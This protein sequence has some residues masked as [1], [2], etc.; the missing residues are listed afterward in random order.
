CAA[1]V[2]A[3]PPRSPR[4]SS[5]VGGGARPRVLEYSCAG[6]SRHTMIGLSPNSGPP[7]RPGRARAPWHGRAKDGS[8][9]RVAQWAERAAPAARRS[10]LGRTSIGILTGSSP[11]HRLLGVE[12]PRTPWAAEDAKALLPRPG[13]AGDGGVYHGR[14]RSAMTR[15]YP[16]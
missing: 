14:R 10:A 11:G 2:T 12:R 16:M 3:C 1:T 5:A 7:T 8:P 9:K 13:G 4:A 15:R 6:A